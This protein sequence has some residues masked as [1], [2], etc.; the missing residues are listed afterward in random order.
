M[1]SLCSRFF[2]GYSQLFTIILH[3]NCLNIAK[4][5]IFPLFLFLSLLYKKTSFSRLPFIHQPFYTQLSTYLKKK[6]VFFL[7]KTPLFQHYQQIEI[8]SAKRKH[9]YIKMPL[10]SLT[11]KK[12]TL[13]LQ[14][15]YS[16]HSSKQFLFLSILLQAYHN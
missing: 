12:K 1:C 11:H 4:K 6:S 5:F 13:S 14:N 7:T 3:K 15:P 2:I 10:L 9:I 8:F 16:Y